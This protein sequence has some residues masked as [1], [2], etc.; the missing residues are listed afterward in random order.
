MREFRVERLGG[1]GMREGRE[2]KEG[3]MKEEGR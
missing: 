3:E 1:G 2:G